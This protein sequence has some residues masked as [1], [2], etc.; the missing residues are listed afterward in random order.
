MSCHLLDEWNE[1]AS[2]VRHGQR[3]PV[4]AS[5]DVP[6]ILT[7]CADQSAKNNVIEEIDYQFSL[8]IPQ[9]ASTGADR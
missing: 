9:V 3:V 5:K 6:P 2:G 1:Q 8:R 7:H 4:R